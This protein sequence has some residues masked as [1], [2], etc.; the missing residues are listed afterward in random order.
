M[1]PHALLRLLLAAL[2]GL[3]VAF[4]AQAQDAEAPADAPAAVAPVDE[5]AAEEAPTFAAALTD[6]ATG[7]VALIVG[8]LVVFLFFGLLVGWFLRVGA[9]VIL[10]GLAPAALACYALPVTQPVASG[11]TDAPTLST[12]ISVGCVS[13]SVEANTQTVASLSENGNFSITPGT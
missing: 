12:W 2:F 4:A 8:L 5:A 10:A 7:I 13:G 1:Q 6:P 3:S 11:Y 9:L